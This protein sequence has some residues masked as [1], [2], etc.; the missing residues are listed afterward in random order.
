MMNA[1]MRSYQLAFHERWHHL[2]NPH[3]RALAWLLDAPNLLDSNAPQWQKKIASLENSVDDNVNDW[4]IDLDRQPDE[5]QAIL[6]INRFTR[7]GRY[8]EKL[9]A[10]YF[11]HVKR[12]HVHGLQVRAGK[13][14]TVGEFDFILREKEG[15]VHWEFATKFYLLCSRNAAYAQIQQ[16]D[17]FVGP[18]L[19]D[20]LGAKMK[21]IFGRQLL[22]GT[23]PAA[24]ALL[25]EPLVAAQALVKGWL[26][27]R[28]EEPV[29][30]IALGISSSHC[31]G[32]W[33]TLAEFDDHVGEDC[34]VLPRLAWLAPARLP[35]EEGMQRA[36]L[37]DWLTQH[38]HD[39]PMPVMVATFKKQGDELL[40]VDRGFVVPN[41]W[42]ERANERVRGIVAP[43]H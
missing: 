25:S 2:K 17:Y 12:L 4:L 43:S 7:L 33:C 8:A 21:K 30:T 32:W 41:D 39:D 16:A 38:F 15:L 22:L 37:R 1:E 14:E 42:K 27:Y 28:K 18:N 5:L 29:D 34:A 40:E 35:L 36:N 9:L 6:D 20:T 23:H 24:Q 11:A 19:A 13:D 31:H 10:V 26:F 3:V